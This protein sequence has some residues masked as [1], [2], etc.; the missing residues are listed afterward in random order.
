VDLKIRGLCDWSDLPHSKMDVPLVDFGGVVGLVI[1]NLEAKEGVNG[2]GGL[3]V[4]GRDLNFGA[5]IGF[6]VAIANFMTEFSHDGNAG[7]IGVMNE[8][9]DVEV[10]RGEALDDVREV[11]ADLFARGGVLG[12]VCGDFDNSAGFGQA[13]VMRGGF[14]GKTHGM[15]TACGDSIVVGG[16]WRCRW[17]LLGGEA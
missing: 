4:G 5:V 13:E 16:V 2:L 12:V 15:V 8:H 9:G 10:A 7:G 3:D 1:G 11:H 14:V 6:H 17:L